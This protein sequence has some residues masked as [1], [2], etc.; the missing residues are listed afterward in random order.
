[1]ITVRLRVEDVAQ[2]ET[3]PLD[4][5]LEP[6][7]VARLVRPVDEYEAVGGGDEAVIGSALPELDFDGGGESLHGGPPGENATIRANRGG[8]P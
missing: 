7:R 8:Q 6:E 1:V 5:G 3:A 4:L 2:R